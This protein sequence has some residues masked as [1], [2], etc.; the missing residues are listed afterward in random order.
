MTACCLHSSSS[1]VLVVTPLS[2]HRSWLDE[3]ARFGRPL[4]VMA[5]YGESE[6]RA[7]LLDELTSDGCAVDVVLTTYEVGFVT[8]RQFWQNLQIFPRR[9]C[10]TWKR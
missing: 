7:K 3:L 10:A 2:V 9:T 1:R 8:F 5:Y 4:R 6:A